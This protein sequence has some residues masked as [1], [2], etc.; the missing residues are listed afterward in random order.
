[1]RACSA[2]RQVCGSTLIDTRSKLEQLAALLSVDAA[3]LR[4]T[5]LFSTSVNGWNPA[6]FHKL[7]DDQGATL[8]FVKGPSGSYGGYTSISWA[9]KSATASDPAAFLFR[10]RS[11]A[12]GKYKKFQPNGNGHEIC[13]NSGYGPC[14]GFKHD[15]FT[16]DSSRNIFREQSYGHTASFSL[17]GPLI[18]S[19]SL[20]NTRDWELEVLQVG[21]FNPAEGE[22]EHSWLSGFS[23][24]DKACLLFL[25]EDTDRM[26]H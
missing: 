1:M 4:L 11:A 3:S 14:F 21:H 8:T 25:D 6:T 12:S 17:S 16:F 19:S 9:S 20:K 10:C 7:C 22:C 15:F 24:Q 26:S 5:R 23:W 13:P 2:Q 18:D